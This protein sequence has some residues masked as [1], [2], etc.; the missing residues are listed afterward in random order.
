VIDFEHQNQLCRFFLER[1]S[2][3]PYKSKVVPNVDMSEKDYEDRKYEQ[4]I[5]KTTGL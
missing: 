2:L 1:R 4:Q 3:T 5:Q